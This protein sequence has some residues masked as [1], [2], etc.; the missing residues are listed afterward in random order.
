MICPTFDKHGYPT[1]ETLGVIERWDPLDGYGLMSFVEDAWSYDYGDV[2]RDGD[3]W[4][5]ITGGWS[6][7]ED[8]IG[9]IQNNVAWYGMRWEMSRR[10]GRHEFW[11]CETDKQNVGNAAK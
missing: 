2:Q 9:A 8:I 1:E 6:G 11:L 7:N 5:L 4:I 10:G 3:R